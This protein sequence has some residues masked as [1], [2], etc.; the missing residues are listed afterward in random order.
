LFTKKTLHAAAVVEMIRTHEEEK[1]QLDPDNEHQTFYMNK[2]AF[3]PTI[4]TI[5]R[6]GLVSPGSAVE[7]F[8]REREARIRGITQ[9]Q[10]IQMEEE[11]RRARD[12]ALAKE[13]AK[14]EAKARL[15]KEREVTIDSQNDDNLLTGSRQHGNVDNGILMSEQDLNI[16][17]DIA[18]VGD[19]AVFDQEEEA[20]SLIELDRARLAS[21]LETSR[22]QLEEEERHNLELEEARISSKFEASRL[23]KEKDERLAARLG[24]VRLAS[25]SETA[26]LQR[27]EEEEARNSSE[28][29]TA[30]LR[31]EKEERLSAKLAQ[32][33][34]ASENE[35]ARLTREKKERL[36]LK[37][38]QAR[39]EKE[40]R[41]RI[42]AEQESIRLQAEENERLRIQ[43]EQQEVARLQ[44]EENERLRIEAEERKVARLQAEENERLRIEAEQQEVARLHAEKQRSLRIE[45]ERQE[46]AARLQVEDDAFHGPTPIIAKRTSR[47][48]SAALRRGRGPQ[49]EREGQLR[50]IMY[51]LAASYSGD[52]RSVSSPSFNSMETSLFSHSKNL[53][54][55]KNLHWE[56]VSIFVCFGLLT[57]AD[58]C[59]R[60]GVFDPNDTS[61]N[62]KILFSVMK[63]VKKLSRSVIE[64]K[65]G[66]ILMKCNQ[67]FVTSVKRDGKCQS[68]P[69]FLQ[70]VSCSGLICISLL[71]S[72]NE[73]GRPG[74]VRS[75]V[76][77]TIPLKLT[78]VHEELNST[79]KIVAKVMV[80]QALVE[81]IH[82]GYFAP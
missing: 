69:I 32:A 78:D 20:L 6:K 24:E 12:L 9:A 5:A 53:A 23:K 26:R 75:L 59:P 63:K 68:V 43:A 60:E 50:G 25:E 64:E 49:E 58:K 51:G 7:R 31:K 70:N 77:A 27:E 48:G 41:Q 10:S 3:E 39:L 56:D 61:V 33:R 18:S 34:I 8:K 79:T 36:A 62:S 71:E 66:N 40:E 16:E 13:R 46:S 4:A 47:P 45:A 1:K 73:S 28:L 42:A 55:G 11:A 15:E 74:V 80:R 17:Y 54:S 57:T 29:Q 44:A 19:E 67:P 2:K 21:Q 14:A 37:V 35:E 52:D 38:E 76:H 72:F 82:R 81:G 22:L 30:R 65:S